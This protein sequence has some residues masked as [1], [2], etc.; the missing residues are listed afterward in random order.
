NGELPLA[1]RPPAWW[2]QV[3]RLVG[4]RE[5]LVSRQTALRNWLGRYLAHETWADR[6]NLWS[7][8]G[9]KR[10]QKVIETLPSSDC[11]VIKGKLREFDQVQQER[12]A[13]EKEMLQLYQRWPR[14]QR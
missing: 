9:R 4:Y 7:G 5:N 1:Y 2:R 14:A 10:L 12:V 3:R 13:V 8:K 6:E 11:L